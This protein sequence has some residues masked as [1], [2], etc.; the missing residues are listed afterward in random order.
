MTTAVGV[1]QTEPS[2]PPPQPG[3]GSPASRRRRTQAERSASTRRK[4]ISAAISCLHRYGYAA[5][6][7]V[8]VAET[9]NVS[10]G[11]M[12]HHFRTKVDLMLAVV[13]HVFA[14]QQRHHARLLGRVQ[15]GPERF[16]AFTDVAWTVYRQAPS[17]AMLEVLMA[18]RSDDALA[19]R[20]A[21]LADAI[22]RDMFD[23]VWQVAQEAGI[24]DREKIDTMVR[25]HLAALRGLTIDMMYGRDPGELHQ[26]VEL[27]K[28]YKRDLMAEL[29]GR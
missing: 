16:M 26:A 10:R 1:R 28:S 27:L 13:E 24:R 3:E 7:T 14:R 18:A 12:L 15:R 5:T 6:T 19:P 21:P 4:L 29:A 22:D 25:L 23:G 17:M 9:A 2:R 8:L 20:L 11:A